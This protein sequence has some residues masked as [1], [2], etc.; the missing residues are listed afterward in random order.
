[1]NN[2]TWQVVF[3]DGVFTKVILEISKV[4]ALKEA[5]DVAN[6]PIE[7]NDYSLMWVYI[8]NGHEYIDIR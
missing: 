4:R 1:M 6:Y 5:K 7:I 2:N 8:T 3:T